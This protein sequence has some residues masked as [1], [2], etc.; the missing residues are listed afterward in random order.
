MSSSRNKIP[1]D[2]LQQ[3]HDELK[4]VISGLPEE[5]NSA[6]LVY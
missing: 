6:K 1:V 4:R 3:D 5:Y 2:L